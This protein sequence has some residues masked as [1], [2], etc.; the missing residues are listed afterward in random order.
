MMQITGWAIVHSIWQGALIAGAL[1]IF[2]LLARNGPAQARYVGS[3]CALVLTLVVPVITA[4]R[5]SNQHPTS[6]GEFSASD[7]SIVDGDVRN[8][9]AKVIRGGPLGSPPAA[10]LRPAPTSQSTPALLPTASPSVSSFVSNAGEK[11][12]VTFDPILHWLVLAW[13]IGLL[14]LSARLIGGLVRTRQLTT[15]DVLPAGG[16]LRSEVDRVAARLQI[17]QV[18]RIV[19]STRVAVPLVIGAIRPMIVVPVSLVTGLAP[20]QLEMLLAHELAHVRRYDYLVNLMQTVIETLLFYHPAVRWISARV[21]DERENCCD[22]LAVQACGGDRTR[23]STALLALEDS[24]DDNVLFAAAATGNGSLLRR[25]SRL[26]GG[27]PDH[28]SGSRWVAGVITIA[29]ALL[30]GRQAVGMSAQSVPALS[31]I[32]RASFFAPPDTI[33]DKYSV[34]PQRAA[35][36]TVIRVTTGSLAER[37]RNAGDRAAS[38]GGRRYWIG[39]LV[40]GD[41]SGQELFH[42]DRYVSIR[43]E[44][45]TFSGHTRF[46]GGGGFNNFHFAG[47][48]LEPLVG[49]H[50]A[51]STAIFILADGRSSPRPIR[52]HL[53]S[54][55][56]PAYFDA[57]PLIWLDSASDAE[58]IELLRSMESRANSID[59]RRDFI[60]AIGAHNNSAAVV[61]VLAATL[62]STSAPKD[63]RQESAEWLGRQATPQSVGAL[64]RAVRSDPNYDVR[65][66]AIEAFEHMRI[67]SATDSLIGFA[68][69]LTDYKLRAEAMESLA[70]RG[71]PRVAQ[72]LASVARGIDDFHV[73]EEAV[74]ALGEMPE[75][76]GFAS[77]V[78]IARDAKDS[79]IRVKAVES[80]GEA[81]NTSEALDVLRRLVN[82]GDA[83]VRKAA[84]EAIADLDT[85]AAVAALDAIVASHQD[86]AVRL[87]AVEA[88]SDAST[89]SKAFESLNKLATSPGS[90]SLRRKAVESLAQIDDPRTV[91]TLLKLI[92]ESSDEYV[93]L[94]AVEA[95]GETRYQSEAVPALTRLVRD[96]PNYNVRKKAIEALSEIE[97][98][99]ARAALESIAKSNISVE[100]RK[101]AIEAYG[102]N[103]S[104]SAAVGF[105]RTLLADP[106]ESI[107][108]SAL[109]ALSE[110][111][112]AGYEAL[113]EIARTTKDSMIRSKA[114]ELLEDR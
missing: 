43:G 114:R 65:E 73:R 35:P 10:E 44:G 109:E 41:P 17:R 42:F 47:V 52:L 106:S 78:D 4:T 86:D 13:L 66:E 62:A 48:P 85:P 80:I 71:E 50:S 84:V 111:D 16:Q 89:P 51:I 26:L 91:S 37:V 55:T 101:E 36:D 68:R 92:Q 15:T 29:A 28:V 60:A 46:G 34:D 5:Q 75:S 25:I 61:P 11:I 14:A 97:G 20:W 45:I 53:G 112:D 30:A 1:S 87:E 67:A 94:E 19:E 8:G 110:L 95:L 103:S 7:V 105:L 9:A 102:N 98:M 27:A 6:T 31:A 93:Q 63:L 99:S 59:L 104:S 58:S 57:M 83:S 69:S 76:L 32:T 56:F 74:E 33:T 49:R 3:L 54:F 39:Y 82:E 72:Y 88:L 96:H 77:L 70:H 90:S 24:R 40:A 23:Y 18:V 21:R 64:S 38:L 79:E 2:L 81:E 22:D 12:A 108:M 113:A 100:L 107:K